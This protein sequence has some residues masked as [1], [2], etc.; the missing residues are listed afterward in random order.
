M[1]ISTKSRVWSVTLALAVGLTASAC[2]GKNAGSGAQAN[3]SSAATAAGTSAEGGSKGSTQGS[4]VFYDGF[5]QQADNGWKTA[6]NDSTDSR[7]KLSL[8]QLEQQPGGLLQRVSSPTRDGHHALQATVPHQLGSF[9]SEVARPPVP[10]GSEDWYGF[11]IY[12]PPTWQNDPQGNILAQWHALVDTARTAGDGTGQPPVALSVQGNQWRLKMHW[13]TQGPDFK[14]AGKGT[15]TFNLGSI[16]KGVWVDFVLHAKWSHNSDGLV[17]LWQD[18]HQKV[19]YTGPDEY[20]NKQGPYFKIGIYHPDWKSFNAAKYR[21]DTA[22]TKPITVYDDAIRTAQ[23][24]A[25]YKD[26]APH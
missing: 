12:L 6:I 17:Q 24:P 13:N 18:G 16:K 21:Q 4:G 3:T 7:R 8:T 9:R 23:G 11:S 20:N 10:M 14:G 22:A 26:V 15:R 2:T 25:S 1:M 19:N 5:E